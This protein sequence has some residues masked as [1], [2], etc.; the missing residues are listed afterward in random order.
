MAVVQMPLGSMYWGLGPVKTDRYPLK[1]FL[2]VTQAS[3]TNSEPAGTQGED[4][5]RAPYSEN[6]QY[7]QHL[8]FGLF[9]KGLIWDNLGYL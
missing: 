8:Q 2:S 7:C 5:D 6:G 3:R 1:C 9:V 4:H